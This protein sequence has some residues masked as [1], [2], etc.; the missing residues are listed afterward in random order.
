RLGVPSAWT[1][2]VATGGLFEDLVAGRFVAAPSSAPSLPLAPPPPPA[3]DLPPLSEDASVQGAPSPEAPA[4]SPGGRRQASW[5]HVTPGAAFAADPGDAGEAA[6][7]ADGPPDLP[8]VLARLELALE[9]VPEERA[10]LALMLALDERRTRRIVREEMD[11]RQPG[12]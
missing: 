2:E 1:R 10:E 6:S 8:D 11:R 5:F 7:E 12:S 3:A 9:G 4:A